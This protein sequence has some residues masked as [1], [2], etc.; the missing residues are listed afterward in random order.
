MPRVDLNLHV[1]I[2]RTPR[3]Q[4]IEGMFDVPE[5]KRALVEFHFDVPLDA[6]PWQVGL[7]VGPSG[8]GKSSVARHLFG[9]AMVDGY[10][11]PADKSVVDGF[12]ALP[13][14][15]IVG[16]MSSVGFA[17]P[18]AW[19]KPFRVLSN[20]ERFRVTLARALMDERP[21]VVLDEFS[22]VVD[23]QVAQ[24]GSHATAKAVR[25]RPRKQFVAVT[26][27]DDVLDWLQ[28][29]WVLEPHVG[30]FTWRSLQRRPS[31]D[32]EIVRASSA[33]WRWFA[34]HHYL[35]AELHPASRCFVGLVGGRP[36][37]FA[38]LLHM[39]HPKAKDIFR[40]HRL[41]VMPDFQGLG[42][43]A[44]SFTGQIGALCRS[45][46]VRMS[47]TTSHPALMRAWAK[48]P[49]WKMTAAP[50]L[51]TKHGGAARNATIAKMNQHGSS[52]RRVASF[53]YVGP[54]LDAARA[55]EA[56]RLWS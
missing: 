28:P 38:A 44:H 49:R 56:R 37:A 34:P 42:L 4:Q 40:L 27:H 41:V 47:V 52:R 20:G 19:L 10:D 25:A 13:I 5:N 53:Q 15:E 14:A 2:Q 29:D 54:S 55:S 31:V 50:A 39:P 16:A 45:V 33:A 3:V 21:L 24:I 22:S 18:P 11:W 48:S 51:G 6:R 9:A 7:V 26:C 12:G 1:D 32:I 8:A 43:G 17:S 35:S 23:R 46:G 30:L 36:A